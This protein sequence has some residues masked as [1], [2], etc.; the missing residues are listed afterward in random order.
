MT[1]K[2]DVR[3]FGAVGDGHTDDT[4][5]VQV[6]FDAASTYEPPRAVTFPTGVFRITRTI[7]VRR[8]R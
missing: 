5:A 4:T 3:D 6:A 2:V 7:H 8:P 1:S